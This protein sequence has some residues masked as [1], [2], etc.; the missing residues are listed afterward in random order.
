LTCLC[1]VTFACSSASEFVFALQNV[2]DGIQ[3]S[4]KNL[5]EQPGFPSNEFHGSIGY[6]AIL[7]ATAAGLQIMG[8]LLLCISY[9]STGGFSSL[10]PEVNY[11]K[12]GGVAVQNTE[13]WRNDSQSG[14]K[15]PQTGPACNIT[16]IS[17]SLPV[18]FL[19]LFLVPFLSSSTC[20]FPNT[21]F[22]GGGFCSPR[23]WVRRSKRVSECGR[24]SVRARSHAVK[25]QLRRLP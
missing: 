17:L 6:S 14:G 8:L 2:R 22:V 23:L 20:F 24:A 16:T 19:F 3:E 9:C 15:I 5:T 11:A 7:V 10:T 21:C 12:M 4:F 1:V 25:L 13:I 18:P